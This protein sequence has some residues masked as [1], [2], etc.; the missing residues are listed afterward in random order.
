MLEVLYAKL[1]DDEVSLIKKNYLT[2][3]P[4]TYYEAYQEI[5]SRYSS[6]QNKGILTNENSLTIIIIIVSVALF[7]FTMLY[8]K[9]KRRFKL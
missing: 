1:K 4:K 8:I 5:L 6:I 7:T 2:N 9:N 3:Y